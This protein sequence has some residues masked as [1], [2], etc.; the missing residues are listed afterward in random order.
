MATIRNVVVNLI[1]NDRRFGKGFRSAERDVRKF[2]RTTNSNMADVRKS[3]ALTNKSIGGLSKGLTKGFTLS[4][5]TA[6]AVGALSALA[7]AAAVSAQQVLVLGAALAPLGGLLAAIPGAI[8]LVAA[9]MVTLKIATSG[10]S[11]AFGAALAGN[12]EK[13]DKALAKMGPAARKLALE[14]KA[15]V[16]ALHTIRN[17]AQAG[18]FG[19]LHGELT[20]TVKVLNIPL[21]SAFRALGTE[22]GLAGREVLRFARATESVKGLQSVFFSASKALS[23]LRPAIQPLLGGF[24]D[25]AVVGAR[26]LT[27]LTPA[28]GAAATAFGKFLSASARS[29]K[30]TEWMNNAL[31]VL[32]QLFRILGNVGS[33]LGSLFSAANASGGGLL[34][35]IEKLT[36]QFAAFLKSTEGA[37][38][39]RAIFSGIGE[40]GK[41]LGPVIIA[42]AQGL[43]AVAPSIGRIATLVGPILTKAINALAP[44]LTKLEPGISALIVGLGGAFEALAPVLPIVAQAL[45]DIAIAIAPVLPALGFLIAKLATGL[46]DAIIQLLP[47][48]PQL[49]GAI[50]QIASVLTDALLDALVAVAPYLPDL[51][52]A[53]SDLLIALIP[54]I[55]AMAQAAVALAPL[56]PVL[57]DAIPLLTQLANAV[58]PA[59]VWGIEQSVAATRAFVAIVKWGAD[60]IYGFYKWLYDKLVGHSIIPDLV[61]GIAKWFKDGARWMVDAV[62][63]GIKDVAGWFGDLPGKIVRAI[64]DL[65]GLLYRAGQSVINGLIDGIVSKFNSLKKILGNVT[66]VIPDWKGPLDTDKRLLTPAG[67]AIMGGLISGIVGQLPALRAVLGTV[68]TTIGAPG[69]PGLAVAGPGLPQP[70]GALRPA[71]RQQQSGIDYQRLAAAVVSALKASGVGAVHLDGQVLTDVVSRRTGQATQLRRRTG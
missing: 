64:G 12:W 18:V 48:L 29:G 36:G 19:P 27:S 15:L 14:F 50:I 68:T 59:L 57:T 47:S 66:S 32:Q 71:D 1:A 30:A 46:A 8:G 45:S 35:T 4:V 56:I 10:M 17:A 23:F 9:G 52:I 61:N 55:P 37:K 54:A 63:R 69:Q 58:M 33:I 41:A 49:V 31:A 51:V 5:K 6:A 42:L 43:G 44:A 26:W 40:I 21:R 39:L 38:T 11:D 70:R 24:R 22:I 16:P 7:G 3:L 53:V 60:Q 34:G 28:I 20:K 2:A 25:L 67:T 62:S 65:G 13:F